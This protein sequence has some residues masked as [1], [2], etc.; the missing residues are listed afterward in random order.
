MN[1]DIKRSSGRIITRMQNH[2]QLHTRRQNNENRVCNTDIQ[3][4][5]DRHRLKST[6]EC[7]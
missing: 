2:D 7:I 6:L 3:R 4:Q 5:N 1:N